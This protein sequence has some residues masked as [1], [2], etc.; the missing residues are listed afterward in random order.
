M[1]SLFVRSERVDGRAETLATTRARVRLSECSSALETLAGRGYSRLEPRSRWVEFRIL[2]PLEVRDN[3]ES[4]VLGGAKQRSLLAILLL[5]ANQV[6]STDRLIDELW[7]AE[8]PDTA[9]KALQVHVSQLR[10]VLEPERERGGSSRVLC[11]RPPGYVL[12]LE[13]DQF[14]LRRFETLAAEGREALAAGDAAKAATTLGDAL[15]LWRGPP[16]ADL[17]YAEFAQREAA[18]LEELR[19]AV[20]EDR[21]QADL[22]RGRHAEVLGELERLVAD[23]PLRERPRAQLMLALYRSGRQAGALDAYRDARRT[24]VEELGIEP[25]RE[26]KQL[27]AA[28]LNQDAVLDAPAPQAPSPARPA[29]PKFVSTADLGDERADGGFVGREAELADLESALEAALLGRGSVFMIG[30]EPG[31]GKSRLADELSRRAV[32]RGADALWGRCWEAGGAPAYWPWVQ[33]LRMYLRDVDADR[34][35]RHLGAHGG[36]VAHILPEIRDELPDLPVPEAPESEGARFRLFDA[37]CSFIERVATEKPVVLVLEDLHAADVPSLL[38]LQFAAAEIGEARLLVIGTYRDIEIGPGHPLAAALDALRRQPATR[39]LWL[40]GFGERDVSR[41][42]ETIAGVRPSRRV[43]TAIHAG[44]GGNPLFVGEL[45]RLLASEGHLEQPIDETDVRLS[46]PRG[47]RDVIAKRVALVSDDARDMLEIASVLGREFAIG[48]LAHATRSAPAEVLDLLDEAIDEGVVAQVPSTAHRL[49]FTHVLIRDALYDQLGASRRRRLHRDLGEALEELYAADREP[50]LAELAQ[51]FFAAGPEGDPARAFDYARRA[52]D[53]AVG[54]LAFEE[55]GRLYSLALRVLDGTA[56][57]HRAERGATLLSLGYAHLRA[58]DQPL[59]REVFLA[60]ADIARELGAVELLAQAALGY[61]GLMVWVAA[62]GDP[63]LIGLL[64]EALASLEERDSPLRAKLMARLSCAIR[65]QPFRQRGIGLSAEAVEM[66]RR[67]GDPSTLAYALD[68]RCIVLAGPATLAEFVEATEELATQAEQTA[69]LRLVMTARFYRTFSNLQVGDTA[70]TW[71]EL[72]AA[73]R[74]ADEL[75]VPSYNWAPTALAASL[76]LVQGAFEQGERLMAL[77]YD[78]GKEAQPVNAEAAVRLQ[79][80]LLRRARGGLEAEAEALRAWSA[81]DPTYPIGRCALA[82]LYSDL[83]LRTEAATIFE[84]VA[85]NDFAAVH[86]DEEWLV[87]LSFLADTARFL[88]DRERAAILYD[89]LAPYADRNAVAWPEGATA[90]VA[91]PLGVLASMLGPREAAER[92]FEAAVEMNDRIGARPWVAH[93]RHDQA[94][95][96]A[97]SGQPG[98]GERAQALLMA[99]LTTYRELGMEPWVQRAQADLA[100]LVPA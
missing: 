52:G 74:E 80:Y 26:L 8:A 96:L 39:T 82:S 13:P 9:A 16:L 79:T 35:R 72:E 22:D 78:L 37:T 93:T 73:R 20:L 34:L 83:G 54:L 17:A 98:D 87:A 84:E 48:T 1:L 56:G 49:R 65:D 57:D 41:L 94:R 91:R 47:V 69:D 58:G 90:A 77:A 67:I 95:M 64:E 29:E 12:E 24:L 2:G 46:I 63:H 59:A 44:T 5:N 70:R 81:G 68:A 40:E 60:A 28:I 3:G 100:A 61:G 89:Q 4:L 15:G 23:E 36:D 86:L 53:R 55:A 31:I 51:H 43:A 50:H 85:G 75:R 99:A 30:G 42:I 21:I 97:A 11:T 45:V 66:A 92:H 14:D 6:V 62:R 27:E 25:G 10:K 32:A 76:A 19:L 18:R 88:G 71:R 38:L 7:G 33:A